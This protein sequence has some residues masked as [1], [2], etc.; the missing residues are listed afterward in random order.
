LSLILSPLLSFII[1]ALLGPSEEGKIESGKFIK[2]PYC[3]E[4]IKI[5]AKVCRYCGREIPEE[6]KKREISE[7]IKITYKKIEPFFD[8]NKRKWGYKDKKGE[9]VIEPQF[10]EALNFS[11][12][13]AR[14]KIGGKWGYIDENG[15]LVIEPKFDD[16]FPFYEGK[17]RVKVGERWYYINKEGKIIKEIN[18]NYV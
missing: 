1:C 2:C 10:D 8:K 7:E 6:I 15:T 3:A 5:E 13:L 12:G 11:E 17:A 14:V 16:G 4:I 9:I 18:N